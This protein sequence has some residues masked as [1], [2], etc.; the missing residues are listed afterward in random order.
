MIQQV[1]LVWYSM[2]IFRFIGHLFLWK[3]QQLMKNIQI[4]NDVYPQNSVLRREKISLCSC[5]ESK[6]YNKNVFY[7]SVKVHNSLIPYGVTR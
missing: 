6:F 1:L 7:K 2:P 5:Y 3:K 4:T